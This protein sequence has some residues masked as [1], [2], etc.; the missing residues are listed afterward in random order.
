MR[1]AEIWLKRGMVRVQENQSWGVFSIL[2]MTP[3]LSLL[4]LSLTLLC[5]PKPFSWCLQTQSISAWWLVNEQSCLTH[6]TRCGAKSSLTLPTLS[7]TNFEVTQDPGRTEFRCKWRLGAGMGNLRGQGPGDGS[8][9]RPWL[10][11]QTYQRAVFWKGA[12]ST[13]SEGNIPGLK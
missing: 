2:L 10:Q 1:G 3:P 4:L 11:G 6:K 8:G 7:E 9:W 12:A 5:D 13:L